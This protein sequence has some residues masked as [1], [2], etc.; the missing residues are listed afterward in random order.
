MIIVNIDEQ[1]MQALLPSFF[2]ELAII[3]FDKNKKIIFATEAFCKTVGYSQQELTTM[4]HQDLCFSEFSQSTQYRTFWTNLLQG[5]SFQDKITRRNAANEAIFLEANYF[6]IF[7]DTHQIIAVAKIAF[8]ITERTERINTTSSNV[9]HIAQELTKISVSGQDKI[10]LLGTNMK[11][12]VDASQM[13]KHAVESLDK[14]TAQIYHIVDTIHGISR[15]TNMLA[16]NAAIEAARA[17]EYGRGFSVVADEVRKLSQQVDQA[18]IE[19]S[20][21][22]EQITKQAA[23]ISE[24]SETASQM[25]VTAQDIMIKNEE[26]YKHL[27]H[28]ANTLQ[29]EAEGLK[30]IF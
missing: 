6:P 27:T 30:Q 1:I 5:N 4:Y 25:I 19:V 2:K 16:L 15:Q 7:N 9:F 17:G 20:N 26:S 23:Q 29:L 11:N 14:Q 13:S 22:V 10:T 24:S 21:S 3:I 18:I 12:V 8:N 28:K